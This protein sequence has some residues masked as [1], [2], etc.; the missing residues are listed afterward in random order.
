VNNY[1]V[2]NIDLATIKVNAALKSLKNTFTFGTG[3]PTLTR[4]MPKTKVEE[5]FVL[6]Y[7][8]SHG[9]AEAL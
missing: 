6:Y 2:S 4:K 1:F 8:G 7:E 5:N 9:E 3:F